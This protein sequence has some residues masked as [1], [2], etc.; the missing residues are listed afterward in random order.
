MSVTAER[1]PATRAG[2][3]PERRYGTSGLT[4]AAAGLVLVSIPD[5]D[6]PVP[7]TLPPPLPQ[8]RLA[9][10]EAWPDAESATFA[11]KLADG[12][13]FQ[14][15]H[16]LDART[17]IG[18]APGADGR[19]LRLVLRHADGS[20]RQLRTLP[21]NRGPE[22]ASFASNATD[23]VWVENT[24]DDAPQIW[25]AD[26]RDARSSARRLVTDVGA[27]DFT[28]A[29]DDL[30]INDGHVLWAAAGRGSDTTEIRS[31]PVGGGK[32]SV[33]AEP[34]TWLLSAWPW[35]TDG[36]DQTSTARLRNLDTKRDVEVNGSGTDLLTCGP[37]WCRVAVVGT[38]GI[39]RTDF[40]RHDGS[41]RT[42]IATGAASAIG[43]DVAV[44]DRFALF[45]E[46]QPV[47]GANNQAT[48]I[49]YDLTLAGTVEVSPAA[50]SAFCRAGILWWSTGAG[51][52]TTWHVLD[53]RTV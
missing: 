7:Q 25:A 39:T 22:F 6:A 29:P 41:A 53:L 48:L 21:R 43:T 44:L 50:G 18:T 23:V 34:G 47:P 26:M 51:D 17:A 45:F 15:G 1:R 27:A 40:M 2:R 16:L 33:R 46:T 12:A 5:N 10:A 42:T 52:F 30:V 35:L 49:A 32:V 24:T 36:S 19:S 37:T 11:G 13:T 20:I 9:S 4:L 14:P 31:V 38:G 3:L 8:S 28:G